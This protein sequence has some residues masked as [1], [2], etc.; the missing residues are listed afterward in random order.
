MCLDYERKQI[1]T[2]GRYL[3][4]SMRSPE[5][6]KVSGSSDKQ[7][8]CYSG[9]MYLE[10]YLYCLHVLEG[11]KMRLTFFFRSLQKDSGFFF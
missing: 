7:N 8:I 4:P 11:R 6:L 2:L 3:D 9:D 10:V 1:F 5:R